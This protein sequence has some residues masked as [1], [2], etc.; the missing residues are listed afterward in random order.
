MA[1]ITSLPVNDISAKLFHIGDFAVSS[2]CRFKPFDEFHFKCV[3]QILTYD[4]NRLPAFF[5]PFNNLIEAPGCLSASVSSLDQSKHNVC[6]LIYLFLLFNYIR[7]E[8]QK[9][10]QYAK[11]SCTG[12]HTSGT[13]I[14]LIN[15]QALR[16]F[17]I[18]ALRSWPTPSLSPFLR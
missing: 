17:Q 12:Y 1:S 10:G 7:R 3:V 16:Q 4:Q 11:N 15:R 14:E 13:A 2:F 6:T 5:R 8:V 9:Y 18:P